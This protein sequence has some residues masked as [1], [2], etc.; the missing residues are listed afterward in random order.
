MKNQEVKTGSLVN[1]TIS[2]K[3]GNEYKTVIDGSIYVDKD[4]VRIVGH[5]S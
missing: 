5:T 2:I 4:G 1:S 3:V